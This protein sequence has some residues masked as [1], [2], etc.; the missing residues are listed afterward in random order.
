MAKPDNSALALKLSGEIIAIMGMVKTVRLALTNTDEPAEAGDVE[1]I[2]KAVH[3][4]LDELDTN[5]QHFGFKPSLGA[6]A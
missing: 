2:L 3:D 1:P 5:I 4:A 6:V